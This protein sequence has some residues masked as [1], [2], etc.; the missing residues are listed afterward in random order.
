MYGR[1]RPN[2][3]FGAI[4][5]TRRQVQ[6]L[7][8]MARMVSSRDQRQGRGQELPEITR[9]LSQRSLAEWPSF[10]EKLSDED[11]PVMKDLYSICSFEALQHLHLRVLRLSE[12]CL[13]KEFACDD[14]Y[15]HS[16]WPA[17]KRRKL[18]L[19]KMSQLKACNRKPV[20]IEQEYAL[21]ESN[22]SSAM[23]ED[24]AQKSGLST[25]HALRGM[26]ERMDHYEADMVFPFGAS[27]I[28]RIVRSEASSDLTQ[29]RVQCTNTVNKVPAHH[30]EV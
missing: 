24:N 27:S 19:R 20:Q 12:S 16:P 1:K 14:V 25:V 7:E 10:L 28:G 6:S 4:S 30:R 18:S 26:S 3:L 22:V 11:D 8:E 9:L 15:S 29:M 21:R 5:E 17:G 2:R 13:T 23:K